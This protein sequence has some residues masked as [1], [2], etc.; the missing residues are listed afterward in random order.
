MKEA[1]KAA[2]GLLYDANYDV[3]LL[4]QR[5]DAKLKIYTFNHTAFTEKE[6]RE[7]ILIS[8]LGKLGENF[9]IEGPFYCDYGY[10]IEIGDNFYANVNFTILDG[11]KVRI[12][13]N[14]FI[15]P[16]VGIYTAGHT[17][18][19]RRRNQGL[20][21]A[22]PVTIGDDVWIGAGVNILP[23]VRIGKGSVIG[24]GAV[25]LKDVP[26]GVLVAGNPA[27]IIRAI[28]DADERHY[29]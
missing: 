10:N 18:D 13:N 23:G 28:T 15:A 29:S 21:Y 11:A 19:S 17:L 1:E 24:A 3:D 4:K 20:E 16:N 25:V 5:D 7:E 27:R 12:G 14:V 22:L 6:K 8:L 26:E 9:V 2:A